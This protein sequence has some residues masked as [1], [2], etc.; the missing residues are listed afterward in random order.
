MTRKHHHLA[1]AM[2][3]VLV[4][5][6]LPSGCS[7]G[8]LLNQA[9]G[10]RHRYADRVSV[11][12]V[13]ERSETDWRTEQRLR[14][15]RRVCQFA[16]K[17][18][19]LPASNNYSSYI[20]TGSEPTTYLVIAA[21]AGKTDPLTW[22]FPFAGTFPYL[23]FLSRKEALQFQD[24][25]IAE[26]YDVVLREANAFST[27]GWFNVPVYSEMLKLPVPLLVETILHELV[28]EAVFFPEHLPLSESAATIIG[29]RGALKFVEEQY[30]SHSTLLKRTRALFS[31][32]RRISAF[33]H[34]LEKDL[35]RMYKT[36]TSD[37]K[38]PGQK[39]RIFISWKH[40]LIR[41]SDQFRTEMWKSLLARNWNNAF[42]SSMATY[43]KHQK[44]LR[45]ILDK[46]CSGKI[47]RFL[48]Y[49]RELRQSSDDPLGNI[50]RDAEALSDD[51]G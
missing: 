3:S 26:G 35:N 51:D 16:Q 28:H 43:S 9:E 6:F 44:E 46:M 21:P 45:V 12:T 11:Q 10:F 18:L 34:R 1:A 7:T 23:G 42:I 27:L 48:A 33:Y 4:L 32:R 22:S 39:H 19:N 36:S 20:D 13:L 47:D 49:L 5:L 50:Q 15:L 30:G 14:L 38:Q 17:C 25:L 8:Y 37:S 29:K 2:F 40:R 24:Q 31:D 41:R